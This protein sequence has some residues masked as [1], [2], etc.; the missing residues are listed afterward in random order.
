MVESWQRKTYYKPRV[1]IPVD[2]L[3]DSDLA[4]SFLICLTGAELC[5]LRNM[6]AYCHRRSTFVVTYGTNDYIAPGN[7]DWDEIQAI[8]SELETKLMSTCDEL[9]DKMDELIAAQESAAESLDLVATADAVA[10]VALECICNKMPTPNT[11]DGTAQIVAG[12]LTSDTLQVDDPYPLDDGPGEDT[13]ACA[14]AQLCWSFAWETLTEIV[15]PAQRK[16]VSVLLPSAMAII[17][18]WIGTPLLGIPVGVIL[19]LLWD[20]IDVFVDGSLQDVANALWEIKEELVCALYKPL[21]AGESLQSASSAAAEVINEMS[22]LSAIDK[23]VLRQLTAPWAISKMGVAWGNETSWA[24][25]R[26]SEGYCSACPEDPIVGDDWIA[27]PYVGD[28]NPIELDHTVGGYWQ[29]G[30]MQYTVPEGFTLAGIFYEV[31]DHSGNC[32]E[33]RMQ[34][35]DACTGE[36]LFHNTSDNLVDG[37]YFA[38]QLFQF[39]NTQCL[40]AVHPG[41]TTQE[42][43]TMQTDTLINAAFWSGWSCT[44]YLNVWIRYLVFKG[45]TPPT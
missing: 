27:M 24:T 3:F 25:A 32:Q 42:A 12:F 43:V 38:R 41:A 35:V 37:W 16:A 30:C 44:G 18:S 7:D 39:N 45:T 8:V 20:V 36:D 1:L 31:T 4:D 34:G 2:D 17:A 19:A 9:L 14:I 28:D 26:V 40:A 29:Q 23:A 11:A 22:E 6:L 15:Q 21:A 13:E 33:K 5:L 10:A